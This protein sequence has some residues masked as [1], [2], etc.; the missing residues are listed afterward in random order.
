MVHYRVHNSIPL[1]PILIRI[2]QSI[3]HQPTSIRTTLM[4]SC[5]LYLALPSGLFPSGF[6]TIKSYMRATCRLH[7]IVLDL[8]ILIIFG[9][10]DQLWSFLLYLWKHR[11]QITRI[12][13]C[14]SVLLSQTFVIWP[15]INDFPVKDLQFL[16]HFIRITFPTH[17]NLNDSNLPN[18]F[19]ELRKFRTSSCNIYIIKITK[20]RMRITGPRD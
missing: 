10:E 18:W 15:P 1:I 4:L 2:N 8:I 9:E 20:I 6:S 11:P 5:Y 16:L 14:L 19:W 3:P 12:L 17:I 7:L 13:W